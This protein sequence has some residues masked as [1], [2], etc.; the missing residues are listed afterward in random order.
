ML[1]ILNWNL[2]SYSTVERTACGLAYSN[3]DFK[4]PRTYKPGIE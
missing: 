2:K 1:H 3:I 4:Q